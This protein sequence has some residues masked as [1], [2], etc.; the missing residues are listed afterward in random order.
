MN[1]ATQDALRGVKII[2]NTFD[3]VNEITKFIKKSPKREA[4]FQKVEDDVIT[5]SPGICILCPTRCTVRAEALS[6]ISENYEALQITWDEVME[7]TQ[8]TEMRARI[9]VLAQM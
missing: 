6:S 2:G 7:A 9:G 4:M 3:T 1:L 8:D 5:E